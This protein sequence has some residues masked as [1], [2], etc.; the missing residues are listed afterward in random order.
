[1]KDLR[2]KYKSVQLE[3]EKKREEI[4]LLNSV[5]KE[6]KKENQSKE[7]QIKQLNTQI[8][9]IKEEKEKEIE[10]INKIEEINRIKIEEE[11]LID[12]NRSKD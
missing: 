11:K 9:F 1:M 4:N 7:E 10:K 3:I 2:I 6:E 5:L 8:I 12:T